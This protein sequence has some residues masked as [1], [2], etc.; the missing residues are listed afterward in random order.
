MT[1]DSGSDGRREFFKTVGRSLILGLTGAGAAVMYKV[2]RIGTCINEDSPCSRCIALPQGCSLPKAVTHR[3][4][5]GHG[6]TQ[7]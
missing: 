7:G 1:P 2:G 3:K 4:Q 6:S 5:E